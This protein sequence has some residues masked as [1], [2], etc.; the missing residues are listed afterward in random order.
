MNSRGTVKPAACCQVLSLSKGGLSVVAA[1][2][3]AAIVFCANVG[4]SQRDSAAENPNA[5]GPAAQIERS[6]ASIAST[7]LTAIPLVTRAEFEALLAQ[8]KGKVVLVD[9]WATWCLPCVEQLPHSVELAMSH[10]DKLTVVALS[11]DDPESADQ[12]RKALEG[13]GAAATGVVC[14]Q[15]KSGT[16]SKSF[17]AFEIASGAL[18][19][20]KLYDRTGKLR[21]TFE[22]DPLAKQQFTLADIDAAVEKLLT[23]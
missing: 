10:G 17:D 21:Q 18:P 13:A 19:H 2:C 20:Y 14:L 9:C 11:F 12:V 8:K 15:C 3:C 16:S 6:P 23:E 7:P 5:S 22:L 4:C 1:L